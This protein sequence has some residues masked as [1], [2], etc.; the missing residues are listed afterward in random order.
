MEFGGEPA[1]LIMD[2]VFAQLPLLRGGVPDVAMAGD[3]AAES[4]N[5][6]AGANDHRFCRAA[7]QRDRAAEHQT[8]EEGLFHLQWCWVF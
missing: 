7:W 4:E 2:F 1:F 6:G 3:V 8:K 5:A